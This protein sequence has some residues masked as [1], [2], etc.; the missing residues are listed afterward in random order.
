MMVMRRY[1]DSKRRRVRRKTHIG[2]HRKRT[3]YATKEKDVFVEK[4]NIGEYC[5]PMSSLD[6]IYMDVDMLQMEKVQD[7]TMDKET[8]QN[9]IS[10]LC[11]LEHID[12]ASKVL[13]MMKVQ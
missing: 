3:K 1:N 10:R 9:V 4:A 7:I 5:N 6:T 2:L 12:E 8:F 13:R 11:R